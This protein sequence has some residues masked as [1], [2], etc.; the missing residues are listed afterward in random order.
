[1]KIT[2]Q[3]RSGED[4]KPVSV[5]VIPLWRAIHSTTSEPRIIPPS[6]G[7]AATK[8]HLNS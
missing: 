7:R 1:M 4:G 6:S 8:R 3:E 5:P 2:C